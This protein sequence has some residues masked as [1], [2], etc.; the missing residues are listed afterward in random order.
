M[1]GKFLKENLFQIF[2]DGGED[3]EL[4]ANKAV[5]EGGGGDSGS[6]EGGREVGSGG[7]REETRREKGRIDVFGTGQAAIYSSD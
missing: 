6:E 4:A 2:V 3:A 1:A 5:S 7:E